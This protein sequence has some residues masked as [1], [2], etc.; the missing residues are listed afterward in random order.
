MVPVRSVFPCKALFFPWKQK[1]GSFEPENPERDFT[2][3]E[4]VG[5]KARRFQDGG[6][7]VLIIGRQKIV[8]Q[9]PWLNTPRQTELVVV[10]TY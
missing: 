1:L 5:F 2:Q 7:F 6:R 10:G 8:C 4:P 9:K 3:C